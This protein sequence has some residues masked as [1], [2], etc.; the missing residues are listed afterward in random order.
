VGFSLVK[1]GGTTSQTL[2]HCVKWRKNLIKLKLAPKK[3]HLVKHLT[4][5]G[6]NMRYDWLE[7]FIFL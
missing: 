7:E 2:A 3:R 1:K 4:T 6:M 5:N